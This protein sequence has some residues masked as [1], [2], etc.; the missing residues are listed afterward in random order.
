MQQ[1]QNRGILGRYVERRRFRWPRRRKEAL[2]MSIG[3]CKFQSYVSRGVQMQ[4][5]YTRRVEEGLDY[6]RQVEGRGRRE[7]K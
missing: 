3:R 1:Y 7:R 6:G 2:C 4:L 5:F